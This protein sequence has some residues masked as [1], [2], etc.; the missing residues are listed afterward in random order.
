MRDIEE[1]LWKEGMIEEA[2]RK[3]KRGVEEEKGGDISEEE[4]ENDY[5]FSLLYSTLI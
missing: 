3:L 5:F 4:D 1:V 2:E